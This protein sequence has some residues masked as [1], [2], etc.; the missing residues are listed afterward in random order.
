MLASSSTAVD[1]PKKSRFQ[2]W[3]VSP[4]VAQ[5][6]QGTTPEK[7]SWSI[8]LGATLGI[9]PIL[10]STSVV[11][12]II[13][14]LFRLNQAVVHLF[15]ALTYPIHLSM[16]IVFIHFGQKLNGVPPLAYSMKELLLRFKESP[17]QFARDFGMAA[18][19]GIEAWALAAL[20]LIPLL[21]FISLPIL[22][23]LIRKQEVNP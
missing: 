17:I 16:I 2:R 20:L 9:F 1:Q 4:I 23:K 8:S 22:R 11:C 5:L 3:V 7:L 18:W 21:R 14:H 19:Y 15:K 13:S 10:G 6:K 12:I